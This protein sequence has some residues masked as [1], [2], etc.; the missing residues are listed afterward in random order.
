[1][2][3]FLHD[4]SWVVPLRSAPLTAIFEALSLLGYPQFFLVFLPLGFWLWDKKLF[5][6]LAILIGI[7][8]IS[9][10][11]LKDLFQDPRPPIQ[12]ALDPRV[13]D[14]FG[15]PSGHAQIATAM[16]LWLAYEIRRAWAWIVALIVVLGVDMSRI[17]LG[18][19]DV[20]DILG[21]T[22]LGLASI[23]I[24]RGLL[25]DDFKFWH[26]L[27]LEFQLLAILA[28]IPFL[29][30]LW[31]HVALPA[32]IVAF[33]LFVACWWGGSVV[34]ERTVRYERHDS[35]LFA[36]AAAVA[37]IVVQFALFKLIGDQSQALGISKA[38]ALSLQF[39][40]ISLFVT[41]IAPAMFKVARLSS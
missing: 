31:P 14:S 36:G 25:S 39:G 17:Y 41:L 33:V 21:G 1:M 18:V 15:L 34:E 26:E 19:H 24:Y 11:F 4:I 35:W 9:N 3:S 2:D 16:W 40:F 38:I 6:R 32:G 7:V 27:R 20:E 23:V 30:A 28:F 37:G 8:G 10:A 5:T 29:W 12:F 13:G 22:L